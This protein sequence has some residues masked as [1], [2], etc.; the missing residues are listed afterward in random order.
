MKPIF[1]IDCRQYEEWSSYFQDNFD[2]FY[3]ENPQVLAKS[4]NQQI[5]IEENKVSNLKLSTVDDVHAFIKK[6]WMM[7]EMDAGS[8]M[9]EMDP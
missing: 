4:L 8:M 2:K 5:L 7:Q 1:W 6:K 3:E 9:Q